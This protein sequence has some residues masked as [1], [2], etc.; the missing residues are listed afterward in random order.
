MATSDSDYFGVYLGHI[1]DI[2]SLIPPPETFDSHDPDYAVFELLVC[3]RERREVRET[4]E[5][6]G[7]GSFE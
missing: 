6:N 1:D 3:G 4:T 2:L 5:G 7:E